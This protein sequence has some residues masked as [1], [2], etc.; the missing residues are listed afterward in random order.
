[1]HVDTRDWVSTWSSG[2]SW[3]RWSKYSTTV[4]FEA[5]YMSMASPSVSTTE[6]G[7]GWC[8][9][10]SLSC[11]S[12]LEMDSSMLGWQRLSSSCLQMRMVSSPTLAAHCSES[13]LDGGAVDDVGVGA[14]DDAADDDAG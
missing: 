14:V 9:K 4:A 13:I 8:S 7:K 3:C 12:K 11:C 10:A 6:D 5:L 2:V 1:M